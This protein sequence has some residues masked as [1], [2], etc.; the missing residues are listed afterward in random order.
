[1]KLPVSQKDQSHFHLSSD[2]HPEVSPELRFPFQ[3]E[4]FVEDY[5]WPPTL[6]INTSFDKMHPENSQIHTSRDREENIA[7]THAQAKKAEKA[8]A[9]LR[10]DEFIKKV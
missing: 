10:L 5:L 6:I 9:S 1:M 3:R 2:N 7:W 8:E 4:L